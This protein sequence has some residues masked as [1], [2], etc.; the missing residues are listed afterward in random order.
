MGL[1]HD[2]LLAVAARRG[3]AW[4]VAAAVV[5]AAGPAIVVAV[6][7]GPV[8]GGA[9]AALFA[10]LF[11]GW[12]LTGAPGAVRQPWPSDE[13]RPADLVVHNVAEGIAIANGERAPASFQAASPAPNV[14]AFEIVEGDALVV[15]D[16]AVA[17]LT[18]D[19]LEAVCAAQLAIAHDPTCRRLE[20]AAAALLLLRVVGIVAFTPV[21]VLTSTV[22]AAGWP[23]M[24]VVT[25]AEIA[26]WL[27]GGRLRWWARIAGDGVA[28]RTTRHPEPLA[29]GLRV[30]ARWNGP[31]VRIRWMAL[32]AGTGTT[33]WAV[34]V[35]VPFTSETR[36]NGRLVDRRSREL[37]EDAKLLV[38]AGL[39]RRV[40]LQGEP[41]TLS[42]WKH[43]AAAVRSAG[44][45]AAVGGV[46]TI[47]GEQVGLDGTQ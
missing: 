14:A 33:R 47:E 8:A 40:C 7:A 46:A 12:L 39:V 24:V 6:L 32:L 31:Q 17:S 35:G 25:A 38:R 30:L 28:V 1:V 10:V 20:G 21:V 37:V 41:A 3:R 45:A 42:A 23:F 43:A 9:V 26:G 16:G 15:T 29:T 11:A 13:T 27:V 36:V 18:R 2:D 34:P 4:C 19:Q 22:P 44:R 5:L